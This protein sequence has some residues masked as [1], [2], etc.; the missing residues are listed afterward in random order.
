M[1]KKPIRFAQENWFSCIAFISWQALPF[2]QPITSK[3]WSQ[4]LIPSLLEISMNPLLLFSTTPLKL[5]I[6]KSQQVPTALSFHKSDVVRSKMGVFCVFNQSISSVQC[7]NFPVV[8]ISVNVSHTLLGRAKSATAVMSAATSRETRAVAFVVFH[9]V[10]SSAR[11][12]RVGPAH[13]NHSSNIQ[14]GRWNG[15]ELYITW[16]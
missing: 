5:Q 10:E 8:N 2:P 6:I 1:E 7:A 3:S 16:N 12:L 11:E 15:P 9:R 13:T 14:D 4:S